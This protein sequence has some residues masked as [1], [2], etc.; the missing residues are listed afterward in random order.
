MIKKHFLVC[1]SLLLLMTFLQSK[2]VYDKL[3]ENINA[4]FNSKEISVVVAL[5]EEININ[6]FV[7][8]TNDLKTNQKFSKLPFAE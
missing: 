4:D 7:P 6:K 8:F 1:I 2:K 3:I 5:N